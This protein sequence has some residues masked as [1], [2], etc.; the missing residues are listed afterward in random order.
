[1]DSRHSANRSHRAST[2]LAAHTKISWGARKGWGRG[3]SGVHRP[4]VGGAIRRNRTSVT[5]GEIAYCQVPRLPYHTRRGTS[6]EDAGYGTPHE[7]ISRRRPPSRRR[8]CR[9]QNKRTKRGK[10]SQVAII[11]RRWMLWAAGNR[12]EGCLA[13]TCATPHPTHDSLAYSGR[14]YACFCSDA[15]IM[16]LCTRTCGLGCALE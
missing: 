1:M 15:T 13:C 5:G 4:R 16:S 2:Q 7:L 14:L 11:K 9:E 12:A 3:P 8:K 6:S 10:G